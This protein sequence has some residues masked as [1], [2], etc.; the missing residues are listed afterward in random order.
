[1]QRPVIE[2]AYYVGGA[3]FPPSTVGTV[4]GKIAG[5]IFRAPSPQ[6]GFRVRKLITL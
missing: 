3:R 6:K 1:M 4:A 2:D 5:N